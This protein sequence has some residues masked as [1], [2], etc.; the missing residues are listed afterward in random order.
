MDR[1][2]L[3][4]SRKL[5]RQDLDHIVAQIYGTQCY[6]F[7]TYELLGKEEPFKLLIN[8][9]KGPVHQL[10]LGMRA[11]TE[12]IVSLLV[13]LGINTHRLHGHSFDLTGKISA[14]PYVQLRW[15]YDMPKVPTV[16]AEASVRWTDMGMLNFRDNNLSLS[17]FHASQEVYLSNMKW[18]HFDIKGG[19][20]NDVFNIRNVR[21]SQI[22]GDYDLGHLNNDFV[23]LFM[24]AR[25]DT[26][27]DGYFPTEGVNAGVSY[28]WT[29][30][31]F[32]HKMR[33]FHT[34]SADAKLVVPGNEIF[35]FIPSVNVRFLLGKGDVP[36]AYFN[37]IGGSLAGRYVDQQLPF[38]GITNL[39]A[40]KNIMTMYRTDFRFKVAE[41]HY[42]TG[43][44]NYVRDCDD[45][46]SYGVGMGYVGAGV[47]YSYDTIFGPLSANIHWSDMTGKVGI[48]L[49]AGY[50]F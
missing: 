2:D 10:G 19:L 23:S 12:E 47:E 11:D 4:L 25:T 18:K 40:M 43:I 38:I 33:N 1:L 6:D 3:D 48:Y 24:D 13:N 15:F 36:V 14:N 30:A 34:V 16:N 39:A 26:F 21:S 29:F 5:S 17:F 35:T 20:R 8:C 37:A 44:L 50:N 31:G 28:S 9:K 45:F 49:S 41:N 22:I 46:K 32:P 7:V 42:V 27:D